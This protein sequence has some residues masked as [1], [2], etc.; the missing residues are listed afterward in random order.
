ML[1]NLLSD[2]MDNKDSKIVEIQ[3]G[4]NLRS[5]VSVS[6]KCH[7]NLPVSIKVPP[8][9]DDGTPF[10]TTYWLTCPMYNKKIGTLESHGM[11]NELDNEL[12]N[13]S[14]LKQEWQSRQE[15]YKDERDTIQEPEAKYRSSG[16]VGGATESIKCLHSHTA[17]ELSTGLNPIG[18]IVLESVGY[19]NCEQPCVDITEMKKNPEWKTIW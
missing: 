8:N 14:D 10:P 15:S 16:G 12:M 19:F 11:I 13:N 17:D 6:C 2:K 3:I 18:K 1:L 7:F 5:D 9:L 4:R